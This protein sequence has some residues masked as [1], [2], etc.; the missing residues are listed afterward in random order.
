MK[1][2]EKLVYQ[3]LGEASMCWSQ[4]PK[5]IFQSNKAVEIGEKLIKAIQALSQSESKPITKEEIEY[6]I[7]EEYKKHR[8]SSIL[9][10]DEFHW[11]KIAASKIYALLPQPPQTK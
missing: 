1:E 7:K 11:A 2:L 6:R 8:N 3:A 5:G 4:V 9:V 10:G